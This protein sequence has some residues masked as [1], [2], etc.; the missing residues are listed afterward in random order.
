MECFKESG[1]EVVQNKGL[2]CKNNTWNILHCHNVDSTCTDQEDTR[3]SH[4]HYILWIKIKKYTVHTYAYTV[5][6]YC[7]ALHSV[8][9]W[10]KAQED[11]AA[12]RDVLRGGYTQ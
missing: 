6:A 8:I 11:T 4:R 10:S 3:D 1:L 9:L 5:Y 2:L 12:Q 7:K